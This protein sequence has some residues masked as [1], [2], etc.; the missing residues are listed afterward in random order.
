MDKKYLKMSIAIL[1]NFDEVCD[2]TDAF[3]VSKLFHLK[4]YLGHY[5]NKGER[6]IVIGQMAPYPTIGYS[7]GVR[8]AFA[9]I[10]ISL[11]LICII[12]CFI[13]GTRKTITKDKAEVMS[14]YT[15][16]EDF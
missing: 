12:G 3:A 7:F 2:P 13:V 5:I 9:S 8:V 11:M 1:D 10:V 14:V 16:I 15:G 4:A 6:E